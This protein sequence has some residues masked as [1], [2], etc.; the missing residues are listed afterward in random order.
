MSGEEL[1]ESTVLSY[2]QGRESKRLTL[3]AAEVEA[4]RMATEYFRA[5]KSRVEAEGNV[6]LA[7]VNIRLARAKTRG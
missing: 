6:G 2:K 5:A 1:R 4:L 3:S 7:G